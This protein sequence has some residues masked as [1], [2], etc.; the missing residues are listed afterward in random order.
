MAQ[1]KELLETFN[2]HTFVYSF[3][4]LLASIIFVVETIKKICSIFGIKFKKNIEQEKLSKKVEE[5]DTLKEDIIEIKNQSIK[6]DKALE[7]QLNDLTKLV[8]DDRIDRMRYEILDMA[9]AISESKR[10]YSVEQLKH[11]LKIYDEYEKFLKEH[12]LENGEVDIS[13]QVIRQ[14]YKS[15]YSGMGV[16]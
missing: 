16:I 7:Q 1:L 6:H 3:F 4:L 15:K 5:I 8:V 13:I 11:T 12:G 10:W 2:F 9:S 14:A